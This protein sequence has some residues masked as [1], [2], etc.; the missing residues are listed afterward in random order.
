MAEK[1]ET[2]PRAG[3]GRRRDLLI[4]F[5]LMAGTI[6]FQIL[7]E[8]PGV[9]PG[10]WEKL[11]I[12]AGLRPAADVLD[13]Y[14]LLVADLAYRT[15]GVEFGTLALRLAGHAVLGLVAVLAYG[16]LRETLAFL[17][18]VRPQLSPRRTGVMRL[19]SALGATAFVTADPVWT[20]GQFLGPTLVLT[21]LALMATKTYLSFLRRGSLKRAYLSAL[22]LGLLIAATP[23]GLA[24]FVVFVVVSC[25]VTRAKRP[26]SRAISP[27]SRPLTLAVGRWHITFLL[28]LGI[29]L[30][31]AV[32]G[33]V[34]ALHGGFAAA[35]LSLDTLPKTYL[36]AY[37]SLVVAAAGVMGWLVWCG[38][39]LVPCAVAILRFP[40][41][42]AE[43]DFM[44]YVAGLVF[45]MCGALALTQSGP[46][47]ALWF[48]TH[49]P[50]FSE[51]ALVCGLFL[52]AVTFACAV[53]VFGIDAYC[54]DHRRLI[55]LRFDIPEGEE[56]EGNERSHRIADAMRRIVAAVVPVLS[57]AV[58]VP[59]VRNGF[60]R[61]ALA[62]VD[63]AVRATLDEAEGL[64]FLF[65]DGRMDGLLE[66]YA[67][68]RGED[69]LCISLFDGAT[70]RSRAVRLRGLED[71]REDRLVFGHDAGMGLRNWLRDRA[72][73]LGR[74]GIQVGFDLWLR[75]GRDLPPA[76]GFLARPGGWSN[77][78]VRVNGVT[79]AKDLAERILAFRTRRSPY[80]TGVDRT[81]R[82]A[83]EG[84]VWRLERLCRVRADLADKRGA[85]AEEAAE[86]ALERRLAASSANGIH[87]RL[88]A[89]AERVRGA[90][91]QRLSVRE[92]LCLALV[93]GDF[94]MG[95]VYA[96]TVLAEEPD[97]PDANFALALHCLRERQLVRAE[98]LFKRCFIR[99]P[100]EA[101]T[102]NNL[103]MVQLER[104][105]LAE[106]EVSV[107]RALKLR[108]GVTAIVD[109][110]R[111]IKA[112]RTAAK[113]GAATERKGT[114]K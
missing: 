54:R 43:D 114:K 24:L 88:V 34:F 22:L 96:E 61:E 16:V 90:L 29:L 97:D 78:V 39:C 112:A 60:V 13:G 18:R 79:R 23:V 95:R 85:T 105:K 48:W 19:A 5:L 100:D 15:L 69:L 26:E 7:W 109:T 94:A 65:T 111:R 74:A 101:A 25:L 86:S 1:K 50:F 92:G 89:D 21:V 82:P 58:M 107:A 108:P 110:E 4:C 67:R 62:I 47:P 75:D 53:T 46:L 33:A 55:R 44:S 99:R 93:R 40:A 56:F 12:A 17:I 83:F 84:V 104:G 73:K 71:D 2:L 68:A 70:P 38:V 6:G 57:F 63:E 102:Y 14:W 103:A 11:A 28:L 49:A 91:L 9:Y 76:G 113:Q 35:D 10:L 77:E 8:F 72:A 80:E 41:A 30:G 66:L 51:L 42:V 20:S 81:V 37:G 32:N 87:A 98:E 3:N 36:G 31:V 106:A 27:F 64:R 45:V 59:A 52:C